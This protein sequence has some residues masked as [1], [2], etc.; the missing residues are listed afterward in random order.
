MGL[1]PSLAY[2]DNDGNL[3]RVAGRT[4]AAEVWQHHFNIV[5]DELMARR[6][7]L[8]ALQGVSLDEEQLALV[9]ALDAADLGSDGVDVAMAYPLINIGAPADGAGGES[10]PSQADAD[11]VKPGIKLKR[12]RVELFDWATSALM[13]VFTF[14]IPDDVLEDIEDDREVVSRVRDEML[15]VQESGRPIEHEAK[16]ALNPPEVVNYDENDQLCSISPHMREASIQPRFIVQ[17]VVA[18]R[19]KLG[20]GAKD[21]SVPGNVELVRREAA[22]LM[23]TWGVRDT[24]A[25]IHLRYVERMFFEEGTHDRLPEWRAR[26]ASKGKLL[27]WL[28]KREQPKYNF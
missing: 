23:R 19:C 21:K 16:I 25:S 22:K 4:P 3:R 9:E 20:L 27:T 18:L 5:L 2:I 13:R 12:R 24:D 14:C 7:V 1:P 10:S 11:C 8:G 17:V 15:V 6:G 26:A 28:F